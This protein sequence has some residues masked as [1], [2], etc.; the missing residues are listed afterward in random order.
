MRKGAKIQNFLSL[1][2]YFCQPVPKNFRTPLPEIISCAWMVVTQHIKFNCYFQDTARR[3][4]KITAECKLPIDEENYVDSFKPHMMDVVNAWCCGSSFGE[5]LKM[6]KIFEGTF[7]KMVEVRCYMQSYSS[8][9]C[10]CNI[11]YVIY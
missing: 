6:T 3:I 11:A 1:S 7:W 10:I 2:S 9:I 5:L 4:A 8:S